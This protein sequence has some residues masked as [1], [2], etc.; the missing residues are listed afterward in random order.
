MKIKLKMRGFFLS[1]CMHGSEVCI[2]GMQ[3]NNFLLLIKVIK[4][5]KFYVNLYL[6]IILYYKSLNLQEK[7]ILFSINMK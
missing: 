4:E 1:S 7:S 5:W 3:R 2:V 6:K